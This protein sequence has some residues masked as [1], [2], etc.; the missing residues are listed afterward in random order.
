ME[1]NFQDNNL[2][3]FRPLSFFEKIFL[4]RDDLAE[5]YIKERKQC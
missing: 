4:N 2:E 3:N 5:Y 1:N